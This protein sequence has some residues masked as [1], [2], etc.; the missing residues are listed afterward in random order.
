MN[1]LFKIPVPKDIPLPLP[2]PYSL[3]VVLLIISFLL[4]ILFINLMLGGSVLT[5]WYE[6][7]GL[8]RKGY[9]MLA[10]EIAKTITVNKSIAIVLGVAPLLSINVL[11]TV[12]FYS[13]NAL[14]GLMWISVIPWV[15][16]SFILLYAHKYTWHKL[17]NNKPLHISLLIMAVV[18]F[19]FIPLIFL[20]NI[21][22]MLFPEKWGTIRGFFTALTLPNVFP[23]YFHFIT[24]SMAVTGL[25]LFGYFGRKRYR[26]EEKFTDLTRY[27]V[28]KKTYSLALG[29][30]IIQ[31]IFGPLVYLTLPTKGMSWNLF[32]FI[33]AGVILAVIAMYIM[34]KEITGPEEKIGRRFSLVVAALALTVVMMATGRHIYRA[35]ALAPHQRLMA[36]RTAK[37][38]EL[39]EK[40]RKG[41]T[42]VV[43]SD[44][45][46]I[47]AGQKLFNENCRVCHQFD[48]RL[49]GPPVT[50]MI[51]IYQDNLPG[52][53]AWVQK[54][55]RKRA[56]YP[57][58]TGFPG[59]S[60]EQ[61]TQLAHYIYN[62][63]AAKD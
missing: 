62:E 18:S 21:N 49:V 41:E 47:S 34:W 60:D 4:H 14:T 1:E 9:D 16:V 35:S 61:L 24:A 55:G 31:F 6:I 40:I 7:K 2:L 54:P 48:T 20:V 46:K 11:Y 51:S 30:S 25:F 44:E 45:T 52:F 27:E 15:A 22:L 50:E 12:Y 28:R 59:L 5:L 63:L 8:T 53:K 13:A 42:T 39:V 37:H 56:D 3:L 36:E 43:V 57:A 32:Y 58:M 19:L 33:S 26:F 23:R 38:H 29:A 17:R 10:L